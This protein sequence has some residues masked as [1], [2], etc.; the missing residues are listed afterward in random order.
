MKKIKS[1][2]LTCISMAIFTGC[3]SNDLQ[4]GNIDN[5]NKQENYRCEKVVKTGSNISS[6][7]CTTAAQREAERAATKEIVE[8]LTR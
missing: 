4:A 6:K 2:L 7:R 5:A 8:N 3:S 1:L